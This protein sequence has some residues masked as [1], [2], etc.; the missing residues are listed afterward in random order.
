MAETSISST[1]QANRTVGGILVGIILLLMA[2]S[3]IGV[4]ALN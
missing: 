3:I 2:I 4:L 1:R